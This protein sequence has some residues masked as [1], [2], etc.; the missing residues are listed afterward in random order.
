MTEHK[1]ERPPKDDVPIDDEREESVNRFSAHNVCFGNLNA[2]TFLKQRWLIPKVTVNQK[3]RGGTPITQ[4]KAH[5]QGI[6]LSTE[7]QLL[8]LLARC[9]PTDTAQTRI[10]TLLESEV[11]WTQLVTLAE[12]HAVTPLICHRLVE[13]RPDSVPAA[14]IAAARSR[15]ARMHACNEVM[16]RELMDLIDDMASRNIHA[17]AF[18]GP[19]LAVQAYG[20]LSLRSFMDLDFLITPGDFPKVRDILR[21]QGYE[22]GHQLS[23]AREAAFIRYA[24]EDIFF[25]EAGKSPVEPHW[26]FAPGTLAVQLDYPSLWTRV[27]EIEIMG[28]RVLTW[29]PEDTALI[30]AIHGSKSL[31]ARLSMICDLAELIGRTP[32]FGWDIL[33]RRAEAQGCLRMVHVALLLAHNLLD[34]QMPEPIKQALLADKPAV[35]LAA[36][37]EAQLWCSDTQETSIYQ[38]QAFHFSVRERLFDRLRYAIRTITTPRVQHFT[39]MNLPDSLFFLYYPIK[40]IHDY[41]LLPLWLVGKRVGISKIR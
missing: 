16:T 24:G 10:K 25:H 15:L 2:G 34:L 30:L 1:S 26:E 41:A 20:D 27:T 5:A 11:D 37:R 3:C 29:G 14:L 19:L 40:L 31:W 18:K 36:Q 7:H 13:D 21:E 35:K 8:L 39:M 38:I 4:A 12:Q 9:N 23:P 33:L 17:A 6:S 22:T 32:G 28:R